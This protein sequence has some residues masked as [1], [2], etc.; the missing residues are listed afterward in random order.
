MSRHQWP[1]YQSQGQ[2]CLEPGAGVS[3]RDGKPEIVT[4]IAARQAL[5]LIGKVLIFSAAAIGLVVAGWQGALVNPATLINRVDIIAIMVMLA[6]L[7]RATRRAFGPASDTV[8]ARVVRAG[9]YLAVFALVLAK[10]EAQRFE[11]TYFLGV[12]R[13]VGLWTGEIA[14]L[15]LIAA[16]VAGLLAVTARHPPASPAA[17]A[18]GT[19][20]GIIA[21]LVVFVLPPAGNPLHL[22]HTW[23]PLMHGLARGVA[24]PL[25]LGGGVAA[26]LMAARRTRGGG[27]RLP[28][29]DLRARQG[30]AAGLCAG[31][32]AA[33]IASIAGVSAAT[34]LP[35]QAERFSQVVPDLHHVPNGVYEFEASLRD[36]A[37][38]YLLVLTLFPLLGAGLGAWGGLYAAGHP[39]YRPGG[40]DG[41]E[42]PE[43]L[44][45][46]PP[47]NGRQ[48]SVDWVPAILTGYLLELPDLPVVRQEREAE[49]P[50]HARP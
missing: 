31:A 2:R 43:P 37:A 17:L 15:L 41:G 48:Q 45:D 38:R 16:Y 35:H 7:P 11:Y 21:G 18:V 9:G 12:P 30:V 40:G 29:A 3:G 23:L 6:A 26:G 47:P 50:C 4:G 42:F 32:A 28:L 19:G 24:V 13:L 25:L 8:L 34:V 10:I 46:P 27:S 39:P 44:P 1:E 20:I 36:S 49:D 22:S 33:L 5:R 14:F